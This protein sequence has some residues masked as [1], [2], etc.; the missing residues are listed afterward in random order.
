LPITKEIFFDKY[1]LPNGTVSTFDPK[2][3]NKYLNFFKILP[4]NNNF[5]SVMSQN[6]HFRIPLPIQNKKIDIF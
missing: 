4:I 2:P 5:F 6:N 3:K 1:P